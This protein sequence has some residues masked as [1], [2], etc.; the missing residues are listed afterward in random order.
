MIDDPMHELSIARNILDIVRDSIP[1]TDRP[2]VRDIRLRIGPYAGV[3]IESLAFGFSILAPND[4]LPH[5]RLEIETT[6]IV[7][8]CA[9]CGRS[10]SAEYGTF[11]CPECG[12]RDVRF[13]SGNELQL[14]DIRLDIPAMEAV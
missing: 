11:V 7:I 9:A 5:A 2:F 3:V 12:G 8:G 13:E 4:G 1:E 14:V 10:A 6:P